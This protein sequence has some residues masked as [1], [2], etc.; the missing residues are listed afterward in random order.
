MLAMTQPP[1]VLLRP[2]KGAPVPEVLGGNSIRT[3]TL[4]GIRTR[5]LDTG[6]ERSKPVVL[7]HGGHFGLFVPISI[8]CWNRN[9]EDL[10]QHSR[11]IAFDKLGQGWTDLP[12]ADE[13]WT[14]DAV[15]AHAERLFEQLDL[16][17]ATVVGHSRGGLLAARLAI[18]LPDRV[19]KL[20]IVSSASLASLESA[21]NTSFYDDIER[22]A[23]AD[24]DVAATISRYHSAQAVTEGPLSEEYLKIAME[25]AT[26]ANFTAARA[27][28]AR[29]AEPYWMPSLARANTTTLQHISETGFDIPVLVIWGQDDRSAPVA[30]GHSLFA[31][32]AKNTPRCSMHIVNK[33]G[34]QVFRDQPAAFAGIIKAFLD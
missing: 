9:I 6:D 12:A 20:V 17:D 28:F 7:I 27:A 5:Y 29:N 26:S 8:E 30:L 13:D 31:E 1:G 15:L 21:T 14:F 4:D 25:M 11:V 10:A 22:A 24:T 33:A 16:S 18:E 2:T 19:S 32:L 3:V 23:S 34:H